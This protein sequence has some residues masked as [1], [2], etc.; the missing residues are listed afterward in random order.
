MPPSGHTMI[1]VATG[2]PNNVNGAMARMPRDGQAYYGNGVPDNTFLGGLVMN[3]PVV[4]SQYQETHTLNPENPSWLPSW[5][6]SKSVGRPF[7]G[8]AQS[9]AVMRSQHPGPSSPDNHVG[10]FLP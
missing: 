2:M 10:L 4:E 6:G 1:P 9:M 8:D 7:E 3:S 5:Q